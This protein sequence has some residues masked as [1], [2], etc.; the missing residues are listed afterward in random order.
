ML[1]AVTDDTQKRYSFFYFIGS[2]ASALTGIL[3]FGFMQLSGREGML[4]WRWIFILEGVVC[5]VSFSIWLLGI[6]SNLACS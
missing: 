3:A 6:G 2:F 5:F 4:G 1:T